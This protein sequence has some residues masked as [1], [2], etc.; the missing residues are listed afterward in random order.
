MATSRRMTPTERRSNEEM[1][2]GNETA[3]PRFPSKL[4]SM[5][6]LAGFVA[7]FLLDY[8]FERHE[9]LTTPELAG[10]YG[11]GLRQSLSGWFSL[12]LG[13]L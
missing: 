8:L 6:T 7:F 3:E 4:V 9:F 5:T 1:T 11:S 13:L 12:Y 10:L 2:K